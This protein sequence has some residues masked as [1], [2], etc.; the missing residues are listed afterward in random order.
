MLPSQSNWIRFHKLSYLSCYVAI[1]ICF[2]CY[3]IQHKIECIPS[4]LSYGR[5]TLISGIIMKY[6]QCW[7][8][9]TLQS[10]SNIRFS[11]ELT[12]SLRAVIV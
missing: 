3:R 5:Y 11:L 8:N 7:E 12:R 10:Y 1:I 2:E 6:V 9:Q 4:S